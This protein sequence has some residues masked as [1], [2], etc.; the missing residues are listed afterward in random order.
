VFP[1]NFLSSYT[2]ARFLS[3]A[4][5]VE[6]IS[7]DECSPSFYKMRFTVAARLRDVSEL[8]NHWG[9]LEFLSWV[10]LM[11]SIPLPTITQ[12]ERFGGSESIGHDLCAPLLH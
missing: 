6:Q 1:E 7:Q 4:D 9:N 3:T 2:T 8:P 12:D 10:G 5:I 11:V